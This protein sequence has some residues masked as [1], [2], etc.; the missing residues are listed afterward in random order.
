[1]VRMI[2]LLCVVAIAATLLFP[3]WRLQWVASAPGGPFP[4]R[5]ATWAG[6]HSWA[7]MR[8]RPTTVVA[9]DGPNTGGHVTL[10]GIPQVAIAPWVMALIGVAAVLHFSRRVG[11]RAK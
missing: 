3:P 11:R 2:R 5:E 6:F 10:N 4:E 9:W 7:Y 8:T 1:M